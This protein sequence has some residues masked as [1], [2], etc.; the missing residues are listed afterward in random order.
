MSRRPSPLSKMQTAAQVLEEN[1]QKRLL[2]ELQRLASN[3]MLCLHLVVNKFSKEGNKRDCWMRIFDAH[4]KEVVCQDFVQPVDF[5]HF[6][7][8]DVA[9]K[10]KVAKGLIYGTAKIFE[11]KLIELGQI[12]GIRDE[13]T[14]CKIFSE[15]DVGGEFLLDFL[16]KNDKEIFEVLQSRY[17]QLIEYAQQHRT[18][19]LHDQMEKM[20]QDL[21]IIDQLLGSLDVSSPVVHDQLPPYVPPPTWSQVSEARTPVHSP[22][23]SASHKAEENIKLTGSKSPQINDMS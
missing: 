16:R 8:G 11:E 20:E 15:I 22:I 10:A 4:A 19:I 14:L 3:R 23:R 6:E 21:R 1:E 2:Q 5:S 18:D 7:T 13:Q 17:P 12:F 9:T